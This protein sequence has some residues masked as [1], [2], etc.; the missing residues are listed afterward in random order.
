MRKNDIAMAPAVH[1]DGFDVFCRV[2]PPG[3]EHGIEL[4]S[5][6][7]FELFERFLFQLVAIELEL[8]I[9]R[10]PRFAKISEH[11]EHGGLVRTVRGLVGTDMLSGVS[12]E[13]MEPSMPSGALNR[14]AKNPERPQKR[15][16]I[17]KRNPLEADIGVL[18]SRRLEEFELAA[19]MMDGLEGSVPSLS[20]A[21][22]RSS[23]RRS[24]ARLPG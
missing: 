1:R 8:L 20:N 9:D 14:P 10:T 19:L 16:L 21:A 3:P 12:L 13:L 7:A 24:S 18:E 11:R 5:D 23:G 22:I 2:K 6:L 4:C 15:N 17:N